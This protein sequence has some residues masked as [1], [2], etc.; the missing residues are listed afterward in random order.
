VG[1]VHVQLHAVE[2]GLHLILNHLLAVD[3]VGAAAANRV[4]KRKWKI[5]KINE[6]KIKLIE[7]KMVVIGQ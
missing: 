5:N 1:V 2:H 4:L 7:G 6:W 3:Q